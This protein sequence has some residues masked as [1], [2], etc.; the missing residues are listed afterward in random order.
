M[1]KNSKLICMVLSLMLVLQLFSTIAFAVGEPAAITI[2]LNGTPPA[3]TTMSVTAKNGSTV[4]L[5]TTTGVSLTYAVAVGDNITLTAS[6]NVRYSTGGESAG[7][8]YTFGIYP[9]FKSNGTTPITSATDPERI[10]GPALNGFTFIAWYDNAG[11]RLSMNNVYTVNVTGDMT[12]RADF[13][14]T[15]LRNQ[16]FR[17]RPAYNAASETK[18]K[19]ALD[20]NNMGVPY[21]PSKNIYKEIY[22]KDIANG[23]DSFYMDRLLQKNADTSSDNNTLWSRGRALYMA[24]HT[25]ATIGF[26]G[27]SSGFGSGGAVRRAMYIEQ[28]GVD[29]YTLAF[30][31]GTSST[32][33]S[34]AETTANRVSTPSHFIS[35]HTIGGA[36]SGITADSTKFIS[37]NNSAVLLL[38][39]NN[40][41]S[42]AIDLN[43]TVN[44]AMVNS[45]LN[46]NELTGSRYTSNTGEQKQTFYVTS[47]LSAFTGDGSKFAASVAGSAGALD[48]AITIPAG[49]SVTMRVVLGVTAS[50]IPD[51]VT[52]YN[53]FKDTANSNTAALK[54][55]KADYNKYFVDETPYI[56]VPDTGIG[57]AIAYRWW[58]ERF[59]SNDANLSGYNNQFPTTNEGSL[60]YNNAIILTQPMHLQDT[61][62]L[63][64]GYMPYGQI[65][66]AGEISMSSAFIDVQSGYSWNNHYSQYMGSAGLDAYKVIGGDTRIAEAFANYFDS[67]ARGQLAHYASDGRN[68]IGY[69]VGYMP[70]NDADAISFHYGPNVNSTYIID[71]PE[72]A[73]VYGAANAAAELYSYAGNT[74]KANSIR[75][76]AN[77]IQSAINRTGAINTP[78]SAS[79]TA[80]NA[81][82]WC[83][84]HN[85]Y[86]SRFRGYLTT[87]NTNDDHSAVTKYRIAAK[88]SNLYDIFSEYAA[89]MTINAYTTGSGATYVQNTTDAL[90]YLADDRHF[91][92]FPYYTADQFDISRYDIP[93]VNNITNNFSNINFTVAMRAYMAALRKYDV[94]QK[95]ITGKMLANSIDW[96]A[97]NIYYPS[98]GGATLA[99]LDTPN[100]AEYYSNYRP[101][102]NALSRNNPYH[103]NLG[104]YN[105]LFFEAM[106]G[107]V[108][109][110]DN[111]IELD[112]INLGYDY[113]MVNNV[114]Y[115]G[116][117][118]SIVW[119]DP[120]NAP[121]HYPLA[122][123]GLSLYVDGERVATFDTL[124]SFVYDPSAATDKFVTRGDNPQPLTPSS[125]GSIKSINNA[126]DVKLAYDPLVQNIKKIGIDLTTNATDLASAATA[127]ASYTGPQRKPLFHTF[128]TPGGSITAG[129]GRASYNYDNL[130]KQVLDLELAPAASA[131]NDGKTVNGP[132]WANNDSPNATDWVELDFG[133][134]KTFDNARVWFYSDHQ[135]TSGFKVPLKYEIEYWNGGKW[136]KP[137][138]VKYPLY[139]TENMNELRM[140]SI[141]AQKVRVLVTPQSGFG[142]AITSI[143]IYNTGA[144]IGDLPV[145]TA[146]I[147]TAAATV[148]KL[149]AK[150]S[151]TVNDDGLPADETLNYGWSVLER[152]MGARTV[153]GSSNQTETTMTVDR[154]GRYVVRFEA[155]DGELSDFAD[156]VINVVADASASV[157][158]AL[159]TM[160]S[161]VQTV[162]QN[163][164][165]R[166]TVID[167]VIGQ[168]A[169]STLNTW[170]GPNSNPHW[171]QITLPADIWIDS[172]EVMW[173]SDGGGTQP[174]L[175]AEFMYPTTG[176]AMIDLQQADPAG[177]TWA[178]VTGLKDAAG[179]AS[180]GIGLTVSATGGSNN[181]WNY[182]GF[183]PVKTKYLKMDMDRPG[184]GNGVGIMEWRIY[185]LRPL[186]PS[187][188]MNIRA[189][190]GQNI[191]P[192]LPT[193]Y[194]MDFADGSKHTIDIAWVP[195]EVTA[196]TN[197]ANNQQTVTVT[198]TNKYY[199]VT[200]EAN[201]SVRPADQVVLVSSFVPVKQMLTVGSSFTLPGK[202]TV[203]YNDGAVDDLPVI[204]D[205][206]SPDITSTA[207]V[208]TITGK[209]QTPSYVS[210]GSTDVTCTLD[211]R[212]QINN[213]NV[214]LEALDG[215]FV[216]GGGSKLEGSI[217]S[218]SATPRTGYKF[219]GWF[220]DEAATDPV[221]T[222][223][224]YSFE[225]TKNV[226]YAAKF[227][228]AS[229]YTITVS[230]SAG[231]T[232]TPLQT[233]VY[234][235][236][237][238]VLTATAANG[239]YFVG[240]YLNNV[241]VSDNETYQFAPT[242]SA[243][244]E[245]RFVPIV[246]VATITLDASTYALD[247]AY[248]SKSEKK[249]T[250]G[251]T[252]ANANELTPL[253][254]SSDNTN[255][256]V[257]DQTG[258]V[259]GLRE[260]TAVITVT[261]PSG[262]KGSCTFTVT[263]TA[264]VPRVPVAT[265]SLDTDTY[266]LDLAYPAKSQKILKITVTPAGANELAFVW[267]SSDTSVAAVDPTGNV[268][269]LGEGTAVITVT[270][271]SGVSD[272]CTFTVKRSLLVTA[273]NLNAAT[274]T[275]DLTYADKSSKQMTATVTPTGASVLDLVWSS[276]D[277]DVATVDQT[278]KVTGLSAGTAVI[279]V[280]APSGAKGSCTF[281]VTRSPVVINNNDGGGGSTTTVTVV[282]TVAAVTTTP[283]A[284]APPS[285]KDVAGHWS[286]TVVTALYS[287]GILDGMVSTDGQFRPQAQIYIDEF[288]A[289][290]T[291]SL[292]L[293]TSKLDLTKNFSDVPANYP[294]AKEILALK[295]AGILKGI[296]N[297]KLGIETM[298]RDRMF[299]I[300]YRTLLM[301]GKIKADEKAKP[302][303]ADSQKISSWAVEAIA[304]LQ[305][306][307]I[308]NGNNGN[309]FPQQISTRAEGAQLGFNILGQ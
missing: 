56:D 41:S 47:Y 197:I 4:L 104:N 27:T 161:S 188:E 63:R 156:V 176:S 224:P 110:L 294:Y 28:L 60:L 20:L 119:Q 232:V 190:V 6:P 124:R 36:S 301:Q 102:T 277:T 238:A 15:N 163:G 65:M 39:L 223:N 174:P 1:K 288:S 95:Y 199:G 226:S 40:T 186:T 204:W 287:K 46:A 302:T 66:N 169:G 290:I 121:G 33:A 196:A 235:G 13:G 259:T 34:V 272:T 133:S 86:E 70:G 126:G 58:S 78:S 296:G 254:W 303:F 111:K 252:P 191:M 59:N 184:S 289:I 23:G 120:T 243:N 216:D 215:G 278:G 100:N 300:L 92:I 180:P 221:S 25:P 67:D 307:G 237:N 91:M 112:P 140:Q 241:K 3:G 106:A 240:W 239:N 145:N 77:N 275:L 293:D 175:R 211:I 207:G 179:A 97:W 212:N 53:Y 266:T 89:P 244:Y 24:G 162:R 234:E 271:P 214:D 280:T 249:L 149:V 209:L 10:K 194:D 134:E 96:M 309:V 251:F 54:K 115:H 7:G 82:L 198:G 99:N 18:A 167:G 16:E 158:V 57:K 222:E 17:N 282:T 148:E 166:D 81:G 101:S 284:V 19:N 255:V 159:K 35:S 236:S 160:G 231:G 130:N 12:L 193:T 267:T 285:L 164:G 295:Q 22:N 26:A 181:R 138:Q 270:A 256:A 279:T 73:Y 200:V 170:G 263:R 32:N 85:M 203:S 229:R 107:I 225:V 154:A 44:S 2:T 144:G 79:S 297:N 129:G 132:F 220:E 50:D 108:P 246:P 94:N 14:E 177:S 192:L 281:T 299:V 116:Q 103:V 247:L 269:G 187:V 21:D 75:T 182:L 55:Q 123:N 253:V 248:A 245:A 292:K 64:S 264:S 76:V 195:S 219:V 128:H 210:G 84:E 202:I 51:S 306:E 69:S 155:D 137:D 87:T 49:S 62:W 125:V 228:A 157:N 37:Y 261:A 265:V 72:S 147:V 31:I 131:V 165:S 151:A 42:S 117:D 74:A 146:P 109:R 286:N 105:W 268:T 178:R 114:R 230:A 113:F 38:Q 250:T 262:A 30:K 283:A 139:P 150:L 168:A 141:T 183:D 71:R 48:K 9:E 142:V 201:V 213:F 298:S 127:S 68:L 90:R 173:C 83:S 52:E 61:K 143:Q 276:S 304:N 273:I 118:L 218:I 98:S 122:P 260:G 258:N 29:L 308:V 185:S 206:Y 291:R 208:K 305:K 5:P 93:S 45:L 153:I 227:A 136:V 152:P 172:V 242:Q 11:N 257:V 88:E 205:S 171:V 43:V 80:P 135:V 233:K 8:Q 217:A 274:Y 189:A